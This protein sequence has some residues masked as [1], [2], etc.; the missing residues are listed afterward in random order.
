MRPNPITPLRRN[1]LRVLAIALLFVGA[2]GQAARAQDPAA[3]AKPHLNLEG[4][5][6]EAGLIGLINLALS[7][8]MVA[9]I[10]ENLIT[11]RR[12]T[13][14][15]RGLA[16]D[17]RQLVR[18]RQ[19]KQAEEF[20]HQSASFL[21]DML[22]AGLGEADTS[23]ARIEKTMEDVCAR[24]MARLMRK[25]EYLAVIGTVAPMLGLLGTVWG[26]MLAFLEF[27][28]KANVQVTE[29]APGIAHALVNTFIGLC[30]AIPAFASYGYLRNRIEEIVSQTAETAEFAVADLRRQRAPR[31]ARPAAQP[32]SAAPA[33][34]P[35]ASTPPSGD[36]ADAPRGNF[37][38][39]TIE[40]G[41]TA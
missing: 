15:P 16:D 2:C 10:V 13:L 5:F 26:V 27:T 3:P 28:G 18:E 38:S 39:V 41:R 36:S 22:A 14:M 4:V 33:S 1:T 17:V 11:V 32:A 20:S 30:V 21:G 23:Y 19:Y 31:R 6:Q 7:I 29:L 9:I 12:G 37:P 25:I 24:Q 34:A 40:R 8:A 35:P